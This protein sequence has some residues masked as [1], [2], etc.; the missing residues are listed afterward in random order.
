MQVSAELLTCISE[1]HTSVPCYFPA[2]QRT[3]VK[4][5][6]LLL[7]PVL[8]FLLLCAELLSVQVVIW[9]NSWSLPP[10]LPWVLLILSF[11][12]L[13]N[14]FLPFYSTA[15]LGT[16]PCDSCMTPAPSHLF[17][18]CF[19]SQTLFLNS[20]PSILSKRRHHGVAC[21]WTLAFPMPFCRTDP[22]LLARLCNLIL[23][24][25]VAPFALRALSPP[26]SPESPFDLCSSWGIF[27]S[28]PGVS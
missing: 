28:W 10:P 13:S 11:N 9:G 20:C 4:T 15:W 1:S 16:S 18:L 21:V 6:T 25:P 14:P 2:P 19:V 23:P 12:H 5:R 22:G 24:N 3:S 27:L 17:C 7:F 26:P 8:S